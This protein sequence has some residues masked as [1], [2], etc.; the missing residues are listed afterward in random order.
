MSGEAT[1]TGR[2][3]P[4]AVNKDTS[5]G[6]LS[7]EKPK[8]LFQAVK[9]T[10]LKFVQPG[11]PELTPQQQAR[12]DLATELLRAADIKAKPEIEAAQRRDAAKAARDAQILADFAN[13]E[14]LKDTIDRDKRARETR[15]EEKLKGLF[16]EQDKRTELEQQAG[17]ARTRARIT[18]LKAENDAAEGKTV[19]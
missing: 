4:S 12:E 7:T 2:P 14:P 3:D 8:G 9:S 16:A 18:Q 15:Q 19:K 1:E 10:V 13:K 11:K 6:G 17:L 5:P